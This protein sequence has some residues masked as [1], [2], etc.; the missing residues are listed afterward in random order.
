MAAFVVVVAGIKAASSILVPF[1]LAIFIGIIVTPAFVGLQKKGVHTGVAL[2]GVVGVLALVIFSGV[3]FL[4]RAITDLTG[5]LPGYQAALQG[6]VANLVVWLQEK[7]VD[8][9]DDMM[10]KLINF[11][12][13]FGFTRNLLSS[14]S[15]ILSNTF[16]I[17]LVVIFILLEAALMPA[18]VRSLPGLTD[19]TWEG[20]NQIVEDVRHYMGMKTL[21][22]L[23]TGLLAGFALFLLKVDNY[24]LMGLLAFLLNYIPT[25]GSIIAAV[26][27]VLI[28]LFQHGPGSAFA[29]IGIY[30]AINVG[31]GNFLEPRIMG[32]GLGLSPLIILLTMVLW[33]WILGP[34]GMLLS[35][36]LTM[37]VKIAL[38]G[39]R[40]TRWIAVMMGAAPVIPSQ[41][42]SKGNDK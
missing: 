42:E 19:S 4:T 34:V 40:E 18:K 12:S 17:L 24:A 25:V 2:L 22:S 30:M 35:V 29:V 21:I 27:A 16:M 36:P 9:P 10:S 15:Q 32:K 38:A 8:A 7:G 20:L 33:G 3:G 11:N 39:S 5:D 26:P 41:P 13:I 28:A 14:F 31:I 37:A 1:L 6:Q 23:G